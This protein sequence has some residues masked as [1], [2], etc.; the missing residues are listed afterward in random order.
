M[1]FTDLFVKRPVLSIVV[2]LVILIAGI[3]SIRALSVRQYP[4]S[5]IAVV[6]VSTVYVGANADLVRGFI[7][8]PL[9]RVIASADG[10]DYMESSSAQGLST[11]TVHLQLNYDTNAAL[12]QIQSKVAQVRNDLPPEAEAPIINLETADN[13]F[14]AIYL[15]FSSTDLDPNQITDYLTRVVQPKLSAISGVQRADI[16][17]ARTFAMRIWLKPDLM[18]AHGIAPSMVR[19][20]LAQNNYLSALGQTKGSMVSVNLVANTD[21]KT[22]EEFRQLVVKQQGGVVVRLGDIADVVLGAENYEQDIR[23]NGESATFMGVWVLP[24]ANTLDVI[25]KVREALPQIRGQL[26]AGMKVGIPYDSTAYIHDAIGEVLRTLTETLLIVIVVIFL[27]LGSFRSVL[28]PIVA[29]PI[30]LVGAVFLMLIAG[31][32]I[33]LLTLLAIVL[34]V[35]LVVDDAIVMVENVERHLH[36]GKRP[37]QA[38]I[39]A[40]RELVGPIIAMTITLAAV[41]APIGIQGG[42]TGSLFRE[43]AF[44]LAGAVIVSG[45]VALTLSPMMGAKLLRASDTDRGFA[46]WINRRF[47]SV[48]SGYARALGATLRYRPVVLTLWVIVAFLTVPF[49]MFSQRELAPAE[50]QGFFFGYIQGSPNATLDQTK[51]F[52]DQIY[53]VYKS[54]PEAASI[55]QLTQ[56]GGGLGGMVTRPWSERTK[57]TQQLM[58]EAMAPLSKI[59]GVRVIPQAPPPLPGGGNFPVDLVIASA[60]EPKQLS[61]LADELVKKAFASGMFLYADADVKFD[62][63]Q[64]EVVFDRDKLRSQG[65]D[66]SQAGRDLS[67][68]VGANYVNRFSIDGRSYKVIPQVAR[69]ERLTPDQLEHIYITGSHDRLVPL[70]TF[71]SLKTTTEP[72]DLKKFQQLNAVRIQG[73][74]PP[75]VPLDQALGF[76]ETEARKIL[77]QGATIDYAGE[78]RQ[79]RTEGGKFLGTFLLSAVLIYLV[80]AAQFESFRD[81]FIVLAGSVPLAVSGALLFSFLGF[82]TLNIYSQVGLITLVGLVSKNGILIV[83]FANHLRETGADKLTAVVEAAT[84]RLRPILM[85]TAATVVGHF[86]LVLA[87]GPGAGARNSIGIMLVSGMIIGTAFTLFVVPS[88][89]MLVARN[90]AA[91]ASA[92]RSRDTRVPELAE[93]V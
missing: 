34:S 63:P 18:A 47:D 40:A 70:S 22:P 1:K 51:L 73:V 7:T 55:F 31:F 80:L 11:I 82:T 88:I 92:V 66:L 84:T 25:A 74:I 16:L 83:Q 20:A 86:P 26:P 2:S 39:D 3:Q 69:A 48:R 23:F 33:N 81:P 42:L 75:P 8:T 56:P 4:R 57:T 77:P 41:Y 30:S 53:G 19:D 68:L 52:T 50:D 38:A 91:V 89:Y 72:R 65:V 21:L 58:M 64:A 71:A 90:R 29:I 24:T 9:E 44:T 76:L 59:A 17:G 15:G 10:I 35:G 62:Q 60:A 45:V 93:A 32:T 43:F 79:L 14:A 87:T 54:F 5:D 6:T 37:V 61:E 12:T 27:F 28:I 78:S 85:T 13:Q 46:G 67:T 36:E 49:Y